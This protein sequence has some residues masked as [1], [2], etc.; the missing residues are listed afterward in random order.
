MR[1]RWLWRT[2]DIESLKSFFETPMFQASVPEVLSNSTF[3]NVSAAA[4]RTASGLECPSGCLF[5]AVS[6]WPERA[7]MVFWESIVILGMLWY[8][9][10]QVTPL[11]PTIAELLWHTLPRSR[12]GG[13]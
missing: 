10:S 9:N 8:R 7:L 4:D 1:S 11:A 3:L 6:I 13:E 5:L 2:V 12:A